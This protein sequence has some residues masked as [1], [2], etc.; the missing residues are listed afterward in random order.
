M[1]INFHYPY[2]YFLTNEK[3]R[4]R[5]E[6][7]VEGG[8]LPVG[9]APVP[10]DNASPPWGKIGDGSGNLSSRATTGLIPERAWKRPVGVEET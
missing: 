7:D 8:N 5:G 4:T 1:Y 2:P 6:G 9:R 10:T 3:E